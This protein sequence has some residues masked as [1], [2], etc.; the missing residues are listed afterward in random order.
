MAIGK[1][2]KNIFGVGDAKN[3]TQKANKSAENVQITDEFRKTFSGRE[4]LSKEQRN[5]FIFSL[6]VMASY[7]HTAENLD[8]LMLLMMK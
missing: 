4:R 8:Y 5:S 3:E 6:L 1:W 7:T 2:M